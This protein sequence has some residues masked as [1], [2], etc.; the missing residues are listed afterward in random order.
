MN[1]YAT[2]LAPDAIRLE[3]LLPGPI[4]RVWA[5][6]TESD[7]R[8]RWLAAGEMELKPGGKV[9]LSF[10]HTRIS[11]EPTPAKYRDMPMGFTGKVMRCDPPRLLAFSWMKAMAAIRK[12]PSN[13][14]A[15]ADKV[16]L[17]ITHR[18]LEDRNALLSVSG[19]WDV[20]VGILEDVL[21]DR[22][23]RGF[24]SSRKTRA[25]IRGAFPRI[26]DLPPGEMT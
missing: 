11:H 25:G 13:L 14:A 12:S 22:A 16:L 23:P 9:E 26:A 7:K 21:T 2:R 10:D 6:L 19:G 8:A 20:H 17:T 3:R 1:D 15:R 5:F 4:E 18:K 24:W